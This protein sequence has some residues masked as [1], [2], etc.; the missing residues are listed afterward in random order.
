M[1]SLQK[2]P[3]NVRL[4]QKG[5][6]NGLPFQRDCIA[7]SVSFLTAKCNSSNCS[8]ATKLGACVNVS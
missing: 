6:P 1:S 7:Y 5:K 3:L 8:G 2:N 4:K